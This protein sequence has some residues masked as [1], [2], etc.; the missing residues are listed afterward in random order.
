MLKSK[1]EKDIRLA[2]IIFDNKLVILPELLLTYYSLVDISK[3]LFHLLIYQV[4][5][6]GIKRK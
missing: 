3:V 6:V 5:K 1:V 2:L 4:T